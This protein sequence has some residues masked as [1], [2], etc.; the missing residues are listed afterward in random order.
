MNCDS[1][2]KLCGGCVYSLLGKDD[3]ETNL[4]QGKFVLA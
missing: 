2:T 4:P 1:L 3:N